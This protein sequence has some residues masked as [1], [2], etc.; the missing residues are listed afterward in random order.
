MNHYLGYEKGQAPKLE[1]GQERQ[2]HILGIRNAGYVGL[3]L[4]GAKF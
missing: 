2:N 3:K 1:A 4:G